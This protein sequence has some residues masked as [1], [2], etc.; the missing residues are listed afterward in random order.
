MRSLS[1]AYP[2]CR[3]QTNRTRNASPFLTYSSVCRVA[4]ILPRHHRQVT[5]VSLFAF[6]SR[7]WANRRVAGREAGGEVEA[8]GD[9]ETAATT[10]SAAAKAADG[11]IAAEVSLAVAAKAS[12][13][14]FPVALKVL[15]K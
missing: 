14:N 9:T 1:L 13:E 10:A 7:L 8:P 11:G 12:G 6:I 5:G 15:P 3:V 2:Y 4:G